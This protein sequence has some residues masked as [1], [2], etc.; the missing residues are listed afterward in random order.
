M[1]ASNS[2]MLNTGKDKEEEIVREEG[3]L[4]GAGGQCSHRYSREL[5]ST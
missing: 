5:S 3:E 1:E 4:R 2:F